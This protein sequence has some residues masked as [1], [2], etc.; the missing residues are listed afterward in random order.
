VAIILMMFRICIPARGSRRRFPSFSVIS[1]AEIESLTIVEILFAF[2][3][4]HTFDSP[5][6]SHRQRLGGEH[7]GGQKRTYCSYPAS[8]EMDD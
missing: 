8:L 7:S 5:V 3:F 1:D 2:L 4:S 6:H